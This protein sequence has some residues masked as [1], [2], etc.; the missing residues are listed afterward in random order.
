MSD[1]PLSVLATLLAGALAHGPAVASGTTDPIAS[2]RAAIGQLEQQ[3]LL[4]GNA[5]EVF[6]QFPLDLALG[7][8]TDLVD[9]LDQHGDQV[10][11][12]AAGTQIDKGGQP[13]DPRRLGMPSQVAGHFH[14]DALTAPLQIAR[15]GPVEQTREQ[16]DAPNQLQLRQRPLKAGKTRAA[17]IIAQFQ[18]QR[19]RA[20]RRRRSITSDILL[21][22]R[23][24]FTAHLG[25]DM[26][27]QPDQQ[28]LGI[29]DR[30]LA[31][32]EACP[33]LG[34]QTLG[35]PPGEEDVVRRR[36]RDVQ[37]E[38]GDP[39]RLDLA[40]VPWEPAVLAEK[41]QQDSEALL[42]RPTLGHYQRP[43]GRCQHPPIVDSLGIHPAG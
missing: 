29:R 35:R 24:E 33:D 26:I 25:G 19:R 41:G 11:R 30:G 15:R 21:A 3:V 17:G 43:L 9:G 23:R 32:A 34:T 18:Q 5:F 27:T 7:A 38:G 20:I 8:R 36:R 2:L 4:A 40:G 37:A 39:L 1:L 10:V 13:G 22:Q 6:Q 42:A 31:D 28:L 16:V 12:Q 14:R